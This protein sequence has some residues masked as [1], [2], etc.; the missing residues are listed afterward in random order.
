M[1]NLYQD[2]WER[3]CNYLHICN[4]YKTVFM[5]G[6]RGSRSA[7]VQIVTLIRS[8]NPNCRLLRVTFPSKFVQVFRSKFCNKWVHFFPWK[9][10]QT[11]QKWIRKRR[12]WTRKS[13][14]EP[15]ATGGF[16]FMILY[17]EL[18]L[19]LYIYFFVFHSDSRWGYDRSEKDDKCALTI[20][21]CFPS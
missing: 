15:A 18:I 6:G 16:I 11:S 12:N 3:V 17:L 2:D 19:A 5:L 1:C 7:V 21:K 13:I 8:P 9:K 4:E 20:L 10:R 14:W